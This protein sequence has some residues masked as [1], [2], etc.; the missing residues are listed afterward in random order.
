MKTIAIRIAALMAVLMS[1]APSVSAQNI[2]DIL[3]NTVEG[4]FTSSDITVE[5]IAGS[6]VTDGPAVCFKSDNFLKKAGGVA[7]AATVEAKIA[8]YYDRFGLNSATMT[9]TKDGAFELKMKMLTLSGTITPGQEKG[10]FDFRFV[11]FNTIPLNTVKAYVEKSIGS[12]NVMFD[13]TKLKTL[14]AGI[15]KIV[16]IKSLNTVSEIL[17][18][19]DGICIGF[20]LKSAGKSSSTNTGTG[21][22]TNDKNGNTGGTTSGGNRTEEKNGLDAL[23]DLLNKRR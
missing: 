12:V 1:S 22:T 14:L 16:S 7:A 11:A 17:S 20:K 4:I 19:Y 21:S 8:P 23:K 15:S 10:T 3:K 5:D 2:G 6:Y 13:A 9:I 18:M